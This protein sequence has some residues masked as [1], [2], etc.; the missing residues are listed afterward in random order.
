LKIGIVVEKFPVASETFIV[1]KAIQLCRNG[2]QVV[3]FRNGKDHDKQLQDFYQLDRIVN[4]K[5][6]NIETGILRYLVNAPS[7]LLKLVTNKKSHRK[8]VSALAKLKSFTKNACDIYHFEFS[9]LAISYLPLFDALGGKKLVSCRGT[10]EKVKALTDP[11]RREQLVKLF[12]KVDRIHCV[13][14]DMLNTI[15]HY[16]ADVAK[17]FVNRP[18]IDIEKF[19]PGAQDQRGNTGIILSVGRLTFQKGYLLGCWLS[20]NL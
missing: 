2:H 10:A 5:L 3:V 15:A 17:V 16:G 19:S 11:N 9:G 12:D 7:S 13:S 6:V 18:A 8:K 20:N 1:N 14:T 4:L